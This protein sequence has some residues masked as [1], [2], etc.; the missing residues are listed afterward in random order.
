[1][2]ENSANNWLMTSP[3]VT[4][5]LGSSDGVILLHNSPLNEAEL[6]YDVN[7]CK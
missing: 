2:D 6:A 5:I 1:M 3:S 4:N 7:G